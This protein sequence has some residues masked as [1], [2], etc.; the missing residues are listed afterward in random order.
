M[1]TEIRVIAYQGHR[2]L[3]LDEKIA[4]AE[5][6]GFVWT[7]DKFISELNKD[8]AINVSDYYF[9]YYKIEIDNEQL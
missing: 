4:I 8:G 3:P 6:L 1:S 7:L 2:E 9:D 5:S